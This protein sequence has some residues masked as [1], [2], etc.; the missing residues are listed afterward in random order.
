MAATETR[1]GLALEPLPED[2][3]VKF[4]E[5]FRGSPS[6]E[7]MYKNGEATVSLP[8]REDFVHRVDPDAQ[9]TIAQSARAFLAD[10]N[11][12]WIQAT[13]GHVLGRWHIQAR[14]G[15]VDMGASYPY[16]APSQE[17]PNYLQKL[18][19]IM[20]GLSQQIPPAN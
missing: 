1:I 10:G 9:R 14:D 19:H 4:S 16:T 3:V 20:K 11:R 13:E 2:L 6:Y 18:R 8:G 12:H 7:V 5:T 17:A 15:S